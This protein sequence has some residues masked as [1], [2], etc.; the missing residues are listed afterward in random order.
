MNF[1]NYEILQYLIKGK[2]SKEDKVALS[3][4]LK[5]F[6]E[7]CKQTLLC[8]GFTHAELTLEFPS[9]LAILGKHCNG[10]PD[11]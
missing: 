3:D 11:T 10:V 4:F 6:E 7:F 9:M 5:K 2:G 1:F 8:F